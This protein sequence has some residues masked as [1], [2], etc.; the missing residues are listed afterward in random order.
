MVQLIPAKKILLAGKSGYTLVSVQNLLNL[1]KWPIAVRVKAFDP[2]GGTLQVTGPA[3]ALVVN[4]DMTGSV[5]LYIHSAT[6]SGTTTIQL[7]LATSSGSPLTWPGTS[8]SLSVEVTQF[9]RTII[10]IIAGS[11]GVLVLATVMRLRRKRRGG[12]R[13]GGER[14]PGTDDDASGKAGSRAH[15]G[16]AG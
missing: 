14:G 15:V 12:G 4:P 13:H 2:A 11:L 1:P 3:A 7:Q 10:V 8:E 5:K 9:G 6:T 16:G